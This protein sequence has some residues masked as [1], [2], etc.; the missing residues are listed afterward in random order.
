[1][2]EIRYFFIIIFTL[3]VAHAAEAAPTPPIGVL[4]PQALI[5]SCGTITESG[6]YLLRKNL[7]AAGDCI[8]VD[9]DFVTLDLNGFTLSG[10]GTG[11]GIGDR[12]TVSRKGITIRNG[13]VTNFRNGIQ[14]SASQGLLIERIQVI[15]NSAY[16]LI[17][18]GTAIVRESLAFE[19]GA[20]GFNVGARSLITG[21]NSSAN[22]GTGIVID[23]GSTAIGNIVDQNGNNGLVAFS[24]GNTTIVNNTSWNNKTTGLFIYC[25]SNVI[26]N[27]A[28]ANGTNMTLSGTG[29]NNVN[30][31]AP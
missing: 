13:I 28:T 25:P 5:Q 18:N 27:T 19:N 2:K 4:V 6:S 23:L 26:G 12:G 16:G 30:N 11:T 21:S 31:V 20:D 17:T 7:T 15:G 24:G 10:D 22:G 8:V 29:C 3:L 14:I 1:M 9:A